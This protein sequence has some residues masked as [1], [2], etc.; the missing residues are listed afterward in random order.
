MIAMTIKLWDTHP[1]LLE[2]YRKRYQYVL[3]DE[4]QVSCYNVYDCASRSLF[5][6]VDDR[7]KQDTNKQQFEL[8][9]KL[10]EHNGRLTV[11]GDD[12]QCIYNFQVTCYAFL[13]MSCGLRFF[14]D[15]ICSCREAT[16][17]T[18]QALAITSV[19]SCDR[20]KYFWIRITDAPNPSLTLP[21][22]LSRYPFCD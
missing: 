1:D 16:S 8:V 22:R 21:Q 10:T 19:V 4:F 3:V 7:S 17:A 12:D 9:R 14:I 11:V 15:F 2:Y 6:V 5:A 20:I 18:L 13:T